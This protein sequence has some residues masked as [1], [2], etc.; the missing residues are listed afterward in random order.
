[1]SN[2][3]LQFDI[4]TL[5][6]D[7]FRSPLETSLLGR[8]VQQG[9]IGIKLHNIRDWATDKHRTVDD[10]P[11]GGGPGMV[12]KPE[13]IIAALEAVAGPGSRKIYLSP[14]GRLFRQADIPNYLKQDQIVLLCGRYEGVDQRVIDHFVD[15][16][17]S[18]GDYI[19][20]GGEAAALVFIEAVSRLV[21]GVV[22]EKESLD[23]ETFSVGATGLLE[24]PQYTRPEEFRGHRVSPVLLSGDHQKIAR[25]RQEQSRLITRDRR[26][27]LLKPAPLTRKA[28]RV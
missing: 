20:S 22:G 16:E 18:I 23:D 1:M 27:D 21:P 26:P 11:Y 6:P 7:F 9:L 8:A 5:F 13:P 2:P 28:H 24:Y 12:L 17:L 19:L 4:L 3:L 10:L 14:R 15:E 25:W